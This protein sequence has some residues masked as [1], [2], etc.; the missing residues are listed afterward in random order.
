M[1][2]SLEDTIWNGSFSP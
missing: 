1:Q 2:N